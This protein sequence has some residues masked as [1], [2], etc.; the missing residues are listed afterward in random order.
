[1]AAGALLTVDEGRCRNVRIGYRNVGPDLFRLAKV[2]TLVEGKV[3]DAALLAQAGKLA[4]ESVEPPSDLHADAAYRRD[5]VKTLTI[6]VLGE[7]LRR[8]GH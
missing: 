7:A 2:E 5:L 4:M 3:A 1:M 8:A 6:R